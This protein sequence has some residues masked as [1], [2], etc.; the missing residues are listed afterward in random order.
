MGIEEPI[1]DAIASIFGGD[2]TFV[3]VILGVVLFLIL[4]MV[5]GSRGLL[6][7]VLMAFVLLF[8][9]VSSAFTWLVGL[10]ILLASVL[11]FIGLKIWFSKV[12]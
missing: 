11:I 4:T 7:V 1:I 12:F 5:G 2:L 10:F 8:A 9:V 6:F 3:G